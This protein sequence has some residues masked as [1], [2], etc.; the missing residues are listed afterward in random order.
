MLFVEVV[1]GSKTAPEAIRQAMAFYAS[2][3][4]KPVRLRK[5]LSGHVGNRLQ[6]ALYREVCTS[7]RG[8]R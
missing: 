6:A 2:A 1:G 8:A 3:D 4:K 5:E 7:S